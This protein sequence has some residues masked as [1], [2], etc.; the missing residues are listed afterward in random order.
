MRIN[1][2]ASLFLSLL[3]FSYN[4]CSV[5]EKRNG[6]SLVENAKKHSF[7][8]QIKTGHTDKINSI[9]QSRDGKYALSAGKDSTIRFWEIPTGKLLKVLKGHR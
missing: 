8:L 9:S 2:F 5:S 7:N 3:V 4:G 1:I 6:I